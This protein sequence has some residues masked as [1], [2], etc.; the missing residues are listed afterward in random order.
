[1]N[2]HRTPQKPNAT[3]LNGITEHHP[4]EEFIGFDASFKRARGA[5]D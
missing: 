5:T 1:M 4:H 2:K 3:A